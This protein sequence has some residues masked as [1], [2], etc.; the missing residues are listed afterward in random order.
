MKIHHAR[1]HGESIAGA[2]IECDMCES[3]EWRDGV[4]PAAVEKS[5][6]HFCST[7]CEAEWKSKNVSGEDHH[8]YAS[9]TVVC[10]S[11]GEST[12]KRPSEITESENNFCDQT[13]YGKWRSQNIRGEDA[14][15]YKKSKIECLECGEVSHR[16]PSLVNEDGQNFCNRA[17]F[18]SWRSEHIRGED[19]PLYKG[20]RLE[21]MGPDWDSVAENVRMRD[22]YECQDCGLSQSEHDRALHVHHITP[23]REFVDEEG[24]FNHKRANDPS[25]LVTLCSACHGKW[26][27]IPGLRPDTPEPPAD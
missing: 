1:A 12:P 22:G 5:D 23:R 10:S 17:C 26:E 9:I 16:P 8:Q 18:D 11:C 7:S 20:P 6:V 14:H 4:P 15:Q 27:A 19:H 25:N 2:K 3:V 24:D 21:S 13:C